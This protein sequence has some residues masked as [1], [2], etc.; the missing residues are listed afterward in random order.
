MKLIVP[1]SLC[2][3]VAMAMGLSTCT[4]VT[5]GGADAE[6]DVLAD[7]AIDNRLAPIGV[8]QPN[9]PVDG[10]PEDPGWVPLPG[11]PARCA[12]ERAEHPERLLT[13]NGLV[14]VL[15]P[16]QKINAVVPASDRIP[17]LR[18]ATRVATAA[19]SGFRSPEATTRA[20]VRKRERWSAF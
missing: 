17:R 10:G 12:I 3:S 5:D 9:V 16:L 14:V 11:M 1:V 15:S 18:R 20:P 7:V 8:A 19:S 13:W 6:S 2:L 4:P